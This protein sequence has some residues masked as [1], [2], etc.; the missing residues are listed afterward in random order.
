MNHHAILSYNL[1]HCLVP[2]IVQAQ[3]LFCTKFFQVIGPSGGPLLAY[4]SSPTQSSLCRMNI[5]TCSLV[6]LISCSRSPSHFSVPSPLVLPSKDPE[7]SIWQTAGRE[8]GT[9]PFLIRE[10]LLKTEGHITLWAQSE[11]THLFSHR[12]RHVLRNSLLN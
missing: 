2:L 1:L 8:Q 3:F 6:S 10:L 11:C 9:C 12:Q 4:H 7:S 5:P